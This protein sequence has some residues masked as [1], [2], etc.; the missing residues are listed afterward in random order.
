MEKNLW[1]TVIIFDRNEIILHPSYPLLEVILK[2]V[3]EA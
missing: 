3:N 2:N 1:I